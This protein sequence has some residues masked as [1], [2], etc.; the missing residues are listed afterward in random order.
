MISKVKLSVLIWTLVNLFCGEFFLVVK[1]T[2]ADFFQFDPAEP[3]FIELVWTTFL[4]ISLLIWGKYLGSKVIKTWRSIGSK[5]AKLTCLG[6]AIYFFI[7][8][9]EIIPSFLSCVLEDYYCNQL[10]LAVPGDCMPFIASDS[11]EKPEQGLFK[12]F[13][14]REVRKRVFGVHCASW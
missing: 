1:Y 3:G 9:F 10:S 11:K 4:V 8:F 5:K 13:S 2:S 6:L 7:M 14:P 12:V